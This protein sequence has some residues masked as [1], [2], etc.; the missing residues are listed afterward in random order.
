MTKLV[1][2]KPKIHRHKHPF[3][4]TKRWRGSYPTPRRPF[5][6]QNSS[7]PSYRGRRPAEGSVVRAC[8]RVWV[9]RSYVDRSPAI[10]RRRIC[11]PRIY[12]QSAY[13]INATAPRRPAAVRHR[14]YL[15]PLTFVRL[16]AVRSSF[17]STW[18]GRRTGPFCSSHQNLASRPSAV[19]TTQQSRARASK[20]KG[21]PLEE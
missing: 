13:F 11:C 8:V 18:D 19:D 7:R 14:R 10:A 2:T 3:F 15:L 20:T 16:C 17:A 21:P 1:T 6:C 9:G 12:N 5:V 4:C